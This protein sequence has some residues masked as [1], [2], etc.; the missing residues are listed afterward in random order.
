MKKIILF[1]FIYSLFLGLKSQTVSFTYTQSSACAPATFY[2]TSTSTGNISS[3]SWNFG[4][5]V[6]SNLQNPT[7][8]Y[9]NSGTY[10]VTLTVSFQGGSVNSTTQTIQ[11]FTPP[12]FTFTKLNDSVCPGASVSFSSSV[13]SSTPIQSYDWDFGDGGKSSSANPTYSYSNP[14]NITTLYSVSLI[15]TD[16]NGCSTKMDRNNYIYVKQ[17]PMPEFDADQRDFCY[18]PSNPATVNFTNKTT[19]TSNNTYFWQF[20]D[21]RNSTSENPTHSY[22]GKAN[23]SVSLTATSLEGCVN[24]ISKPTYIRIAEFNMQY[25]VSDTIICSVPGTVT[26][27]GKNLTNTTYNWDF[28]NGI[29]IPSN[30]TYPVHNTYTSSGAY[31]VKVKGNYGNGACVDSASFVIHVYDSVETV[32][33]EYDS[34]NHICKPFYPLGF[35]D[36]TPYSSDDDFGFGS[37]VWDFGDGTTG[38]GDTISHIFPD[39]GEYEVTLSVTTPYGCKLKDTSKIIVIRPWRVSGGLTLL[40]DGCIPYTLGN[41]IFSSYSSTYIDITVDWGDGTQNSK[42]SLIATYP[43][44]DPNPPPPIGLWTRVY[45]DT[46]EH[47]FTDTIPYVITFT[48]TNEQ[49]CIIYDTIEIVQGGIPPKVGARYTYTEDCY[50]EFLTRSKLNVVAFDSLDAE[51]NL[52]AGI[53][54]DHWYWL[55][56]ETGGTLGS[57]NRDST[58]LMVDRLGYISIM[59]YPTYRSCPGDTIYLDSVAFVCPPMA[60]FEPF[61]VSFCEF[62]AGVQFQNN[63][64]MAT[65]YKWYFGDADL[66]PDQSTDTA[67]APFFEYTMSSIFVYDSAPNPGLRPRLV[68]YNDDSLNVNSPTYNKCGF[69]TDTVFGTIR[70]ANPHLYFKT[71]TICEKT[72]FTFYDRSTSRPDITGWRFYLESHDSLIQENTGWHPPQWMWSPYTK[73]SAYI[74]PYA[75]ATLYFSQPNTYTGYFFT[76]DNLGCI[77]SDTVVFYVY[78]KSIPRFVSGKDYPDMVL[79]KDTLCL[80]VPD[81]LYLKDSSYT[82]AP[83]DTTKIIAWRWAINKDTSYGKEVVYN[84]LPRGVHDVNMQIT[85]QY[86]CTSETTFEKHVLNEEVIAIFYAMRREYCNHTPVE[87]YNQSFIM[88]YSANATSSLKYTWDFGDGSPLDTNSS[89]RV[90]HTY[91]LTGELPDTVFITLTVTYGEEGC[92]DTYIDTVI[93]TGPVASFTDDGHTF[94]CPDFGRQIQFTNTST[95]NPTAYYWNFGDSLSGNSNESYLKDPMHD[96]LRAGSYDLTLIVTDKI[97]CTDTLYAPKHVFIDGPVGNFMYGELEGCAPYTVTFIP[98]ISNADS[99]IINPDRATEIARTGSYMNDTITFTY[100]TP[101]SYLPY[102]YLIKWTYDDGH[103]KR[104]VV[105]WGASDSI[106]V[107]DVFADFDADSIYCSDAPITLINTSEV[108]PSSFALDSVLWDFGDGNTAQTIDSVTIQYPKDGVYTITLHAYAKGCHREISKNAEV[109]YFPEIL[110]DLDSQSGCDSLAFDFLAEIIPPDYEQLYFTWTFWDGE[111]SYT[112]PAKRDFDKSGYYYYTLEVTLDSNKCSK[113]FTDSIYIDI[114]T[115]PS[116]NFDALPQPAHFK[117]E[118]LF[119]DLSTYVDGIIV[120]WNWDFGDNTTGDEQNPSHIY[121]TSGKIPVSLHIEDEFGCV[122]D[123]TLEIIILESLE[124]ANVLTPTGSDGRK[125]VFRP[126]EEMG[127]FKEFKMH[128]YNKWGNLIWSNTC[129]EPGCPDYS[130]AFWWDGRNKQGNMVEDGVYY[131]VVSAVPLSETIIFVKNGSVTVFNSK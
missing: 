108:I 32:F 124:F 126:L 45:L 47:T 60:G 76:I 80:N 12:V 128:I 52:I 64:Y 46:S 120:K 53:R 67:T 106:H 15:V 6:T 127:Y 116:A 114:Y 9:T 56:K 100:Q 86:G 14:S 66:L 16:V 115:S 17:K 13:T 117:E 84:N 122:S 50:S 98:S 37:I 27:A 92:S 57:G 68:A 123:T 62:P 36:D 99:I 49:G 82:A 118:I 90:Y 63:S 97:G 125:Y 79:G 38:S 4:D 72:N 109:L 29:K 129:K 81:W 75:G 103:P 22:T 3:Y 7:H 83:F 8:P 54:A 96:Y 93:I 33:T 1:I 44:F 111:K 10:T 26:V 87:F 112:N 40:T 5:G 65:A 24:S 102:F 35:K 59:M 43:K 21:G 28:G 30:T 105:E 48:A 94:P 73:D 23:Y 88:P 25:T 78:P 91:H 69:C 34:I 89:Q 20:G 18:S 130:D 70:I 95:G 101:K 55:N 74:A 39:F 58:F 77:H 31:I 2:F 51:G 110:L 85:N 104:C 11:I 107:I 113:T 71:D 61:D 42:D 121:E 119:T 19:V 131:W 41:L